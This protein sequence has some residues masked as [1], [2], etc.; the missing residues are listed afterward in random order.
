M[1]P[2]SRHTLLY[3]RLDKPRGVEGILA[4][5]LFE[6]DGLPV[7]CRMSARP[8]A[9]SAMA[10]MERPLHHRSALR[11]HC[12]SRTTARHRTCL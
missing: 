2:T 10:E 5:H 3:V 8:H 11:G 12:R 1:W 7:A 6:L 4:R 9:A